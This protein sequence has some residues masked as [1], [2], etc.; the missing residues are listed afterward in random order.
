MPELPGPGR[1][2]AWT[3]SPPASAR[4]ASRARSRDHDLAYMLYTSGST[5][6]P[7]GV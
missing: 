1:V 2:Y 6:V 5:G 3:K 7:K 4:A